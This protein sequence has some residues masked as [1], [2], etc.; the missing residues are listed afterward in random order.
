MSYDY[1]IH[2]D[3]LVH[4][5]GKDIDGELDTK[6]HEEHNVKTTRAVNVR[7]LQRLSDILAYGL[8]M[9]EEPEWNPTSESRVPAAPVCCFTEL[10][11]SQSRTHARQYGRLGIG[12]KRPFLFQRFGR[13]LCYFGF[14]EVT[15]DPFLKSCARDLQDKNMMHFFK[16]MNSS[17]KLTYDFYAESEWRIVYFAE[18]LKRR[19]IV[20]PRD[21]SNS[22][23]HAYSCS[24]REDE[25]QKLKFLIPLDGWFQMIIYPSISIKNEAQQNE[26]GAIKQN[27]ARIKESNDHGN[28]V[29][30]GNWPVEVN[31]DSC[32]NL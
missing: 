28:V 32:R 25:Q 26:S 21:P 17:R 19:R 5:T 11:L 27:I 20:D 18:L 23:E 7:Y 8:W 1:A 29:E 10:K 3:Y 15:D 31:L 24:L 14:G 12:V 4:W 6:W 13:P 16:R 2:S 9:T 22:K 30:K